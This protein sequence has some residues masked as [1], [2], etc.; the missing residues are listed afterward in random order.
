MR[1]LRNK[2]INPEFVRIEIMVENYT[3]KDYNEFQE[4]CDNSGYNVIDIESFDGKIILYKYD[5]DNKSLY[6]NY[7]SGSFKD[8]FNLIDYFFQPGQST[9]Y[10]IYFTDYEFIR[11]N[12]H[13]DMQEYFIS[14]D[15]GQKYFRTV[16]GYWS[17]DNCGGVYREEPISHR[18]GLGQTGVYVDN[19]DEKNDETKLHVKYYTDKRYIFD[20]EFKAPFW[21]NGQWNN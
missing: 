11:K 15:Y 9:Y 20:E 18:Y 8:I 21:K 19:A 2:I 14:N 6:V 3:E 7:L 16:W 1:H 5:A 13:L 12:G 4:W 10:I 17:Y